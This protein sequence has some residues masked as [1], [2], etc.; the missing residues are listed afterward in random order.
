MCDVH[1]PDIAGSLIDVSNFWDVPTDLEVCDFMQDVWGHVDD[2][3][4][5]FDM[6]TFLDTLWNLRSR[7]ESPKKLTTPN[8]TWVEYTTEQEMR[9]EV[10]AL[11]FGLIN[12]ID[13]QLAEMCNSTAFRSAVE[14]CADRMDVPPE[15]QQQSESDV[16]SDEDSGEDYV[17][18]RV[19][20]K[21]QLQELR[22][23]WTRKMK[24]N[25][26]KFLA[27]VHRMV[28]TFGIA[29][30]R[31]V[32]DTLWEGPPGSLTRFLRTHR[33]YI[34]ANNGKYTLTKLGRRKFKLKSFR[35]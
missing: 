25:E 34:A 28:D 11:D 29:I 21:G 12:S 17:P 6:C 1:V 5:E 16:E 13:F 35:K 26:A 18:H 30:S 2:V 20:R 8:D 19:S 10:E 14:R 22:R 15:P 7:I 23:M 4:S 33:K 3:P 24:P 32:L 9:R 27:G 31:Q